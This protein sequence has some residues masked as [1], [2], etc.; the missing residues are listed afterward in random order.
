MYD[1]L[2]LA[3]FIIIVSSQQYQ[4]QDTRRHEIYIIK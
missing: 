1:E 3:Q 4:A 2:P